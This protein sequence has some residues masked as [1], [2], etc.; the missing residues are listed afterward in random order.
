VPPETRATGNE[1]KAASI[2]IIFALIAT[3]L[4]ALAVIRNAGPWPQ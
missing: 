2:A 3:A 4:G 1:I